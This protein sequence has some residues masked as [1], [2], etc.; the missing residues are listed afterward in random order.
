MA[1]AEPTTARPG[2]AGL[3]T[4][5][6]ERTVAVLDYGAT[7]LFAL[8]GAVIGA[9]AGLDLFGVLVIAVVSAL[10]GGTTRDLLIG[11][12]PTLSVRR[13]GYLVVAI[14]GG[15]AAFAF[16]ATVDQVPVWIM[17]SLDA[18]GLAL[19]AVAGSLKGLDF[20]V[21]AL[22]A[23][24]LGVLTAIGG[25]RYRDVLIGRV[26]IVLQAQIYA[27]AALL[28]AVIVVVGLRLTERR[29]VV[30]TVAAVACFALRIL[31]VW[32]NWNLPRA[33]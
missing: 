27:T 5:S 21:P 22:S 31:A 19:F 6:A 12:V 11:D 30:V 3:P 7:G 13:S 26:P 16:H 28:G 17:I 2:A 8:E 4:L 15:L 25:G 29:T 33:V 10:G 32:G 9:A 24:F 23:C 14:V 20:G 18:G 1:D